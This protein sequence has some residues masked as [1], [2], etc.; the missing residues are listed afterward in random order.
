MYYL[1]KIDLTGEIKILKNFSD[2]KNKKV[3]L[4][5]YLIEDNIIPYE[6]DVLDKIGLYCITVDANNYKLFNNIQDNDGYIL[7]GSKYQK[8]VGFLKFVYYTNTFDGKDLINDEIKKMKKQKQRDD[9]A[10]K[11]PNSVK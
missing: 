2:G 9:I 4:N 5:N 1:L 3:I 8:D 10:N 6:N 11:K 7:Y